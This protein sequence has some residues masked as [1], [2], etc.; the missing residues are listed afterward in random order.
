ML[1]KSNTSF[2][3]EEE[4]TQL[5]LKSIG[6]E[7]KISRWARFYNSTDIAIGDN[8]RIDDF[9]ILSGKIT[10]GSNIH[11]SA[12][13]GL[14]GGKGIEMGDYS[15]LSPRTTIFSETDDFSGASM[16][17]PMVPEM[18]RNLTAKKVVIE[19][20]VQVGAGSVI[21]PGVRL[22]EG[23]ATAAMS[24]INASFDPWKIVG[25]IPA[26]I[27]KERSQHILTLEKQI[28]SGNKS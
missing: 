21:L 20:Y 14:Y 27:L 4:L 18:F 15:G 28:R 1:S 11:I 5:G 7:V 16:V 23:C 26:K 6:K 3:S 9:C 13:C 10:M 12:Y 2:L 24:F 22:G 25:G 19:K 17:G 8:V